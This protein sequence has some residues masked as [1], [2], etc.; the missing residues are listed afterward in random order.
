MK[1]SADAPIFGMEI[2]FWQSLYSICRQSVVQGVPSNN[3]LCCFVGNLQKL[4]NFDTHA[5][6]IRRT[7]WLS[8]NLGELTELT[9]KP[10]SESR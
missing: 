6:D 10:L 4:Q 8:T 1:I 5:A 3:P 9:L 7:F 2:Q